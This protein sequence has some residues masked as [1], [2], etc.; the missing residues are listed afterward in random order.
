MELSYDLPK[1]ASLLAAHSR[2]DLAARTTCGVL[3][4]ELSSIWQVG[5]L[6]ASNLLELLRGFT[7][8]R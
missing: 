4:E 6:Y 7:S 2:S 1:I 3:P 8:G 5:T